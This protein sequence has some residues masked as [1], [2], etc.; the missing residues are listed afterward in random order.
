MPSVADRRAD[1]DVAVAEAREQ[2]ARARLE[3]GV[4]D[5][6]EAARLAA[7]EQVLGD[8]HLG[9]QHQ[10]LMHDGDAGARASRGRAQRQRLR[11]RR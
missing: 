11:R 1:V 5:E 6:A 10:L 2:R 4:V 9:H 7:E 3:R 8:G